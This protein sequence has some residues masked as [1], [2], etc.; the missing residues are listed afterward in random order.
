MSNNPK[1]LND[2]ITFNDETDDLLDKKIRENEANIQAIE[3]S[4]PLSNNTILFKKDEN[5]EKTPEFSTKCDNIINFNTQENNNE[6]IREKEVVND[7]NTSI[8]NNNIINEPMSASSVTTLKQENEKEKI[9]ENNNSSLSTKLNNNTSN[10]S[11]INSSNNKSIN[12]N[13]SMNNENK[14]SSNNNEQNNPKVNN[15]KENMLCQTSEKRRNTKKK[16]SNFNKNNLNDNFKN[17]NDNNFLYDYVDNSLYYQYAAFLSNEKMR[18]KSAEKRQGHKSKINKNKN[19]YKNKNNS[20]NKD[21]NINDKKFS[22]IYK[23]FLEEDKKKKDKL[24]KIKKNIEEDRKKIY[25]YKPEINKKSK[26][27]TSKNK[28]DFYT[29]QKKLMEEKKKNNALLK[30]KYKNNEKEEKNKMEKKYRKKSVEETINK[31][32]EWETKRKE[33]INKKIEKKEKD[34]EKELK[35][36]S[37]FNKKSYKIKVKRNPESMIN[38]LYKLDVAKRKENLEILNQIYSPSF[39]PL[40]F[41]SK[42]HKGIFNHRN[43]NGKLKDNVANNNNTLM[44][45]GIKNPHVE[46]CNFLDTNHNNNISLDED[47]IKVDQLIRNR[48][49]SKVKDKNQARYQSAMKF[50][51]IKNDNH[52]DESDDSDSIDNYEDIYFKDNKKNFPKNM[53]SSYVQRTIKRIYA[54]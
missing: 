38:R 42:S 49:F 4:N 11:N 9:N 24:N 45:L 28:E 37:R 34:M 48:V 53:S 5:I 1:L 26:E 25:L 17:M 50:N 43:N 33:K 13:I 52:D 18:N 32:Y 51:V 6:S 46:S 27:I 14:K 40:I 16:V 44:N 47:D 23:R 22:S 30:Y 19:N 31:I 3:N 15:K 41:E 29:R 12:I 2:L 35:K 54:Y 20:M 21:I 7:N 39:Q 36:M 10:I 8:K